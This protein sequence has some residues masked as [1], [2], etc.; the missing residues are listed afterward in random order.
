MRAYNTTESEKQLDARIEYPDF[1]QTT[2]YTGGMSDENTYQFS[3]VFA[4]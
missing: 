3:L 2:D 4:N 1:L